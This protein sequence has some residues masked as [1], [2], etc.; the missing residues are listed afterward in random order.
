[1]TRPLPP[2]AE[3]GQ[4]ALAALCAL[5]GIPPPL[6]HLVAKVPPPG[7]PVLALAR[8]LAT[9]QAPPSLDRPQA[10][11]P[12]PLARLVRRFARRARFGLSGSASPSDPA[13]LRAALTACDAPQE[14][15]R[16]IA[17]A[18]AAAVQSALET[19]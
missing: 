5:H 8:A 18:P 7:D 6:A 17:N 2:L 19:P 4:R 13:A 3:P 14:A 11:G 1:M 10:R 12:A 9:R 15:R 16:L